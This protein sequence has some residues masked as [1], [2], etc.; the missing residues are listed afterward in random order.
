MKNVLAVLKN[1]FGYDPKLKID[2]FFAAGI[3]E[4]KMLFL[5]TIITLV[6]AKDS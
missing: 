1:L 3:P 2:D 5:S 6:K 4:T